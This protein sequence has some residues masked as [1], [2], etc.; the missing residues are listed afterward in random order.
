MMRTNNKTCI[1]CGEVYT[2]CPNCAQFAHL[3]KWK[4]IFHNENCKKLFETVSDFKQNE[5]TID[6]AKEKIKKILFQVQ[7][8]YKNSFN[9]N[10]I[11]KK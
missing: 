11:T 3:P 8:L 10:N 2:Y 1:V 6:E 7:K 9:W 5:I 4:N